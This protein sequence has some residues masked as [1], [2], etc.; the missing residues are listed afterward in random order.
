MSNKCVG[1]H[2]LTSTFPGCHSAAWLLAL[3]NSLIGN[4]S[5]ALLLGTRNPNETAWV[6]IAQ[7][8]L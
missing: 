4:Y 2:T 6:S 8:G 3:D 1:T 7:T 5:H